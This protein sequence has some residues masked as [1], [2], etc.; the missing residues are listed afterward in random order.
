MEQHGGPTRVST[1]PAGRQ[2][3]SRMGIA[4]FVLAL[5]A[6]ALMV[7]GI[8]VA[9]GIGGQLFGGANPQGLTPQDVQRTLEDS[10]GARGALAAAGIAFLAGPLLY[11]L[12]LALG[13]AGVIQ[14]RRRKL[15]AILGA[16][17]NGLAVLAIVGLFVL[18]AIGA[19]LGAP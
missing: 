13:I 1:E 18:A 2:G 9:V 10:P 17:F 3:H 5:L 16:V 7:I 11:L 6:T 15:F 12:G 8:V 19:S 14:R 4:S